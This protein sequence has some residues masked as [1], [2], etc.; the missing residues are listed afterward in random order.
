MAAGGAAGRSNLQTKYWT[1]RKSDGRP[2]L[3]KRGLSLDSNK[4][5]KLYFGS[6][7]L[8]KLLFI[9]HHLKDSLD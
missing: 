3:Y 1:C 5:N 2:A 7:L 8:S 9:P 4:D 6:T